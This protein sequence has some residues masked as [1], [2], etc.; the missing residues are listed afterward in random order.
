[1]PGAVLHAINVSKGGVPKSSRSSV[2][3]TLDGVEGDSQ[4]DPRFHGGPARAVCIYSL[5]LIEAL[6]GEGHPIGAG[7]VGENFTLTGVEWAGVRPGATIEVGEVTLEVTAPAHPCKN[8]QDSFYD[9]NFTRISQKLHP[10]WSRW[11]CRV[12]REGRVAAGDRVVI[13]REKGV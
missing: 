8:I 10:G 9:R 6:R 2:L 5:E 3:V 13:T 4:R 7:T 12:Q 11:Y 1:V